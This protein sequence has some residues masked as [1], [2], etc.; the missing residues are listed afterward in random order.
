MAKESASLNVKTSSARAG[1]PPTGAGGTA[2]GA[3]PQDLP[4]AREEDRRGAQ[5]PG[6]QARRA[7][8]P[9]AEEADRAAAPATARQSTGE[10]RRDAQ[11]APDR[12]R[13]RLSWLEAWPSVPSIRPRSIILPSSVV[14]RPRHDAPTRVCG[15]YFCELFSPPPPP[16]LASIGQ[17]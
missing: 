13:H 9:V 17:S 4:A 2:G 16:T 1:H 10:W 6:G 12:R 3:G 7:G 8:D 14:Y 11:S 5:A 15:N